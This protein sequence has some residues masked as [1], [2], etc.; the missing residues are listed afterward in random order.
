M[1]L[2]AVSPITTSL[3]TDLPVPNNGS[4]E[5]QLISKPSSD[6]EKEVISFLRPYSKPIFEGKET[7]SAPLG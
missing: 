3:A 7:L 5:R 2:R 4:L 6:I 1:N